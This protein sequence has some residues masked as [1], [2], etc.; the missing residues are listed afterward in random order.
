[1]DTNF[2]PVTLASTM[3]CTPETC[4]IML[5]RRVGEEQ[6]ADAEAHSLRLALIQKMHEVGRMRSRL[7]AL[8]VDPDIPYTPHDL[9]D[10]G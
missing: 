8:G 4:P 1:V 3:D 10:H 5:S 9:Q 6:G 7:R 2:T